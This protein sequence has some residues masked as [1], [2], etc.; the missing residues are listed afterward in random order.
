MQKLPKRLAA[1]KEFVCWGY[2]KRQKQ[3]IRCL[4]KGFLECVCLSVLV[5]VPL[6]RELL[7]S[8]SGFHHVTP[9]ETDYLAGL[10]LIPLV[11]CALFGTF[12]VFR[13]YSPKTRNRLGL[14][15]LII[16]LFTGV[17][18]PLRQYVT[19]QYLPRVYQHVLLIKA[20]PF[21]PFIFLVLFKKQIYS[22]LWRVVLFSAPFTILIIIQLVGAL[23][24]S[25]DSEL[26]ITRRPLAEPMKRLSNRVVWIVFDELDYRLV[27]PDRP[28]DLLLPNF[29]RFATT[30]A[31][32]TNATPPAIQTLVSVPSLVDG[33]AYSA[34]F[35]TAPNL[36]MLRDGAGDL[37][38]WGSRPNVFTDAQ[39]LGGRSAV[40]GWYLPYGRIFRNIVDYSQWAPF[41][42][43]GFLGQGLGLWSTVFTHLK[44]IL[45]VY[46]KTLHGEIE[47]QLEKGLERVITDPDFSL[48][49][50]HLP[51]PHLPT[52]GGGN[53]PSN[54]LTY[55]NDVRAY[56]D[57]LKE[58]DR[59]LGQCL[60]AIEN[61]SVASNTTIIVSSD[62]PWRTS[63]L[64]DRKSDPRVP[65]M[66]RFPRQTIG[67][68]KGGSMQTVETRGL[69][70]GI[71][72]T[73]STH[74]SET[75]LLQLG[76]SVPFR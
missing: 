23:N 68:D 60:D 5:L 73:A 6:W 44:G 47:Q 75:N 19:E 46:R 17:F 21:F 12:G 27:F 40:I 7:F 50:L 56:F 16:C 61:S 49:F 18:N 13:F 30:S 74:F 55:F 52:L 11:A 20:A 15:V 39:A 14:L 22:I 51:A 25:G 71:L 36:L 63:E 34:A 48:C 43:E 4:F 67:Y 45:P 76:S 54:A 42:P 35:P 2:G 3:K 41:S 8:K 64:F 62:H 57:N 24:R 32:F 38:P 37:S 65:F 31:R 26:V 9:T 1:W 59:V 66:L 33:V 28:R 70:R 29:D 58:A 53:F 72:A 69:I 10:T